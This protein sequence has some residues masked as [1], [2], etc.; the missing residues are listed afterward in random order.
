MIRS[1]RRP[2][3]VLL[4]AV[5]MGASPVGAQSPEGTLPGGLRDRI[6]TL[7][8]A[9]ADLPADS[10]D[11][12]RKRAFLAVVLERAAIL[13]AAGQADRAQGL[14]DDVAGAL[15]RDIGRQV[16]EQGFFL[17]LTRE[18][19][20]LAVYH[21]GLAEALAMPEPAFAA[22]SAEK[23]SF[24]DVNA[25]RLNGDR[26]FDY[27]VATSHPQSQRLDD[28]EAFTRAARRVCVYIE[29]QVIAAKDTHVG[30]FFAMDRN[31]FAIYCFSRVY[32]DL[33]LPSQRAMLA[34]GVRLRSKPQEERFAKGELVNW[35]N[36]DISYAGA[37]IHGG[38]L[39]GEQGLVRIGEAVIER[40]VSEQ[41]GDGGFQYVRGQNESEGYHAVMPAV[42]HRVWLTTRN[43]TA[44]R[45]IM[46]SRNYTPLSIEPPIV[47]VFYLAPAWKWTW[48]T[49]YSTSPEAAWHTRSPLLKT[50]QLVRRAYL[51]STRRKGEV[52]TSLAL[53]DLSEVEAHPLPDRYMV[54]DAN[55]QG[56]RGRH[57]QFGFA[58][59]G[60][61]VTHPVGLQTFVGAHAVDAFDPSRPLPLNSAVAGVFAGPTLKNTGRFD[62]TATLADEPVTTVMMGRDVAALTARYRLSGQNV[63]PRKLPSSWAGH[64]QWVFLP[65]R[66]VGIVTV[67]P[68]AEQAFDVTGR[69]KLLHGG[70]GVQYPKQIRQIDG[71]RYAYGDIE[72]RVIDH[73]FGR[74]DV[75][76]NTP[77]LR[78]GRNTATDVRLVDQPSVDESTRQARRYDRP[79]YFV[80]EARYAPAKA[81]AEG[82]SQAADPAAGIE[83]IAEG[84]LSGVR[85]QIG[86]KTWA[87][88]MNTGTEAVTFR[89]G[90]FTRTARPWVF[91]AFR[92]QQDN[93]AGQPDS[94]VLAPGMGVLL[95]DGPGPAP[96]MPWPSFDA[97]IENFLRGDPTLPAYPLPGLEY[98]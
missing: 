89:P 24:A 34:D 73:S 27:L 17:P 23:S 79:L 7:T 44:L 56:P 96:L 64:Q 32:P 65:D 21:K 48:N 41:F 38:L 3:F 35:C 43:P 71:R 92:W 51:P 26:I 15:G 61:P 55:T 74:V 62:A 86:D 90:E 54:F 91:N 77:T 85:V 95:I 31:L 14:V 5:L 80:V 72:V 19:D 16:S 58:A 52:I 36:S 97:M 33:L 6:D 8:R 12:L 18:A 29:S 45:G 68:G 76:A 87:S 49:W 81:S 98:R 69:I 1:G 2:A 25:S 13:G 4:A 20:V 28:I 93:P 46:Q 57:G 88:L 66:I 63:G 39:S 67:I 50:Y 37:L 42:L 78:E 83:R 59:T 75:E 60:R 70:T 82:E 10:P 47:G 53:L 30:D 11:A 22:P 84:T 9:V 40:H 94:V